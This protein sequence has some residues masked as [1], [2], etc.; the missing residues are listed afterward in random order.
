MTKDEIITEYKSFFADGEPLP[1][2]A[3]NARIIEL[4][5]MLDDAGRSEI[6]MWHASEISRLMT[7]LMG[8]EVADNVTTML[9]GKLGKNVN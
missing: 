1:T 8:A 3:Q 5:E 7:K 4:Q 2:D 6:A 9:A